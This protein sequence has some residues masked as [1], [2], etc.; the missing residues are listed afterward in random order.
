[1]RMRTTMKTASGRG[2]K[3]ASVVLGLAFL[4]PGGQTRSQEIHRAA[5]A[6]DTAAI[7]AMLAA[8]STLVEAR[9]DRGRTPLQA[10]VLAGQD[11][12]VRLLLKR[13]ADPNARDERTDQAAVDYAFLTES[14]RGGATMTRLLLSRGATFDPNAAVRG[15]VKRLDVAVVFGNL[16][17]VRLLLDAGADP[18]GPTGYPMK[19]LASAASRGHAEI[20]RVL[21]EAGADPDEP[22]ARGRSPS[23]SRSRRDTRMSW[24]ASSTGGPRRPGWIPRPA[25]ASCTWPPW[26]DTFPWWS[27]C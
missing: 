6:G 16:D 21:L 3:L 23:A 2:R 20:V 27:G 17:M 26:A 22:D 14:Q 13:G 9:D 1:M 5:A 4:F 8:D 11:E 25:R 7:A 15:P 12:T 19:P 18:N 24:R 10:A